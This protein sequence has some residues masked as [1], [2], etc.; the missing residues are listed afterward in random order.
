MRRLVG[1]SGPQAR[2]RGPSGQDPR[3]LP[4]RAQFAF[5]LSMGSLRQLYRYATT[6]RGPAPSRHLCGAIM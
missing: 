3:G 2:R 1:T 4:A 5:R 6:C